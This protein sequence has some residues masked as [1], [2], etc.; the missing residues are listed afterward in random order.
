MTIAKRSV[1]F[2]FGGMFISIL[3]FSLPKMANAF[4]AGYLISDFDFYNYKSM[5]LQSI[6]EFLQSQPGPLKDKIFATDSG[7]KNAATIIYEVAQSSARRSSL[8]H[9]KK[10]KV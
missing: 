2:L 4:S 8:Q 7:N 9:Y 3:A 10:N 5:S 1:F 6:K